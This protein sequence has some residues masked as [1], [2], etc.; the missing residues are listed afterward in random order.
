MNFIENIRDIHIGAIIQEKLTEKSM[1]VTGLA[2]KISRERTT[3]H[4]IFKRK[5][6]DTEL[7]IEISKALDYDFIHNVYFKEKTSSSLLIS[8]KTEEDLLKKMNLLEKIIRFVN[9]EE[10]A[11]NFFP[12]NV[13]K[14]P[15]EN[16][17]CV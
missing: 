10:Q 8:I 15:A 2:N 13:E 9:S 12:E 16:E 4:D 6:I 5:S 14:T 11:V 7:L 1:T 3:V 17:E